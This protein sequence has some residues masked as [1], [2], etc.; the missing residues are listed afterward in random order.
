MKSF[1]KGTVP[2]LL[3]ATVASF[4]LAQVCAADTSAEGAP[5]YRNVPGDK[6][7]YYLIK[8]DRKGS[9]VTA[10]HKRVGVDTVGFSQTEINC[11]TKQYRDLGYG[12][13]GPASIRPYTPVGNWTDLVAGSSKSDLVNFVCR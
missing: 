8:Q 1:F 3:F 9:I 13:D 5:L 7:K 6:G 11:A 10:V 2:F 4:P 12:E